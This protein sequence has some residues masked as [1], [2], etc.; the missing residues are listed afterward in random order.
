MMEESEKD[1][2]VLVENRHISFCQ[3]YENGQ[4]LGVKIPID[5]VEIDEDQIKDHTRLR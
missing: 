2:T 1:R 5:T 3:D 4:T